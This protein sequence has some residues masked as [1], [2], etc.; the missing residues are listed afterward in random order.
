MTAL[1]QFNRFFLSESVQ[2]NSDRTYSL[3]SVELCIR[4]TAA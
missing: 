1:L 2:T 3:L 4:H